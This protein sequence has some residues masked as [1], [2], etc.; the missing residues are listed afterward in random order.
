LVSFQVSGAGG[1]AAVDNADNASHES[2]QAGER[3]AFNG[4]CVV[5]VKADAMSGKISL[6]ASAPGLKGAAIALAADAAK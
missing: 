6:T 5:F 2:F 3:S 4:R 1:I